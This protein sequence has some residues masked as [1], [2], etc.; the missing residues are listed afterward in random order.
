[1]KLGSDDAFFVC[2]ATT[3][4]RWVSRRR[5]SSTVVGVFAADDGAL[6][7]LLLGARTCGRRTA[8]G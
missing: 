8:E 4:C 3:R 2:P 7:I 6:I 1:M 5:T